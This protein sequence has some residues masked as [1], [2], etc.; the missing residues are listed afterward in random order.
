MQLSSCLAYLFI[1]QIINTFTRHTDCV[2]SIDFLMFDDE[3]FICLDQV[4]TQFVCDVDSNK[5][6]Q[7]FNGYLSEVFCVKFSPYHYHS[8][9]QNVICSSSNNNTIR[10]WNFKHNKQ[11]H[12]FNELN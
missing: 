4:L 6:M 12:I 10:F 1:I 2:N 11:L 3:Q 8:H 5:Q 9:R 7:S